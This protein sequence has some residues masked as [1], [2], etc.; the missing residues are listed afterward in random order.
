M[1]TAE[2]RKFT[3]IDAFLSAPPSNGHIHRQDD[4]EYRFFNRQERQGRQ[5]KREDA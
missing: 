2:P 5:E 4:K 3:S 1:K